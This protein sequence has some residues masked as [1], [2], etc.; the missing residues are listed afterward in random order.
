VSAKRT[1]W[2][3]LR[4]WP[5]PTSARPYTSCTA[6]PPKQCQEF[7]FLLAVQCKF[8]NAIDG[9]QQASRVYRVPIERRLHALV[10]HY[11]VG[12]LPATTRADQE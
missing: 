10:D 8:R 5:K 9:I 12:I 4:N 11:E 3:V 6:V 1:D 7:K 2:L